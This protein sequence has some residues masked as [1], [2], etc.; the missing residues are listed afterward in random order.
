MIESVPFS[1]Y[2]AYGGMATVKGV[3]RLEN[4]ELILDYR[5]HDVL[6]GMDLMKLGFGTMIGKIRQTNR[7]DGNPAPKQPSEI[8]ISL[9]QVDALEYK[10]GMPPFHVKLR[11]RVRNMALL[12]PIP[13]SNGTEI[14]LLCARRFKSL[15]QNL[16]NTVTLQLLESTFTD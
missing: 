7:G 8:H 12:S 4:Q 13:G 5:V 9:K 2:G 6:T 16:A 3:L 10:N 14:T 1:V 11:L 15:A